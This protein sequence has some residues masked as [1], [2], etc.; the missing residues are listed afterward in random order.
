ME[1]PRQVL[2]LAAVPRAETKRRVPDEAAGSVAAAGN[3]A[4]QNV[5]D[6]V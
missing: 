4:G 2:Q 5:C 6:H 1:G 3:V